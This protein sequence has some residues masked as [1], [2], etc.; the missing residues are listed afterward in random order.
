MKVQSKGGEIGLV[1]GGDYRLLRTNL[2]GIN[3]DYLG[4]LIR[5]EIM[6]FNYVFIYFTYKRWSHET[7]NIYV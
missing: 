1:G 6:F 5:V 4:K 7:L 3:Y 2:L